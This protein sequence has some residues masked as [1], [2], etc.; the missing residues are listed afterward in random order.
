MFPLSISSIALPAGLVLGSLAVGGLIV[1][2]VLANKE[3]EATAGL[4][5][6]QYKKK[7][8]QD[9]AR[10]RQR[11]DVWR[12]RLVAWSLVISF[13]LAFVIAAGAGWLSFGN[14]KKY[15]LGANGGDDSAAT[16]FALLLDAGALVFSLMRLF[17]AISARSS[18]LTR[19]GL[20]TFIAASTVMNLM[21]A[22]HDPGKP[23]S[24]GAILYVVIPPLVYAALLEM[25]LWKAEQLVLGLHTRR[26]RRTERGYSLWMWA[27]WPIGFPIRLWRRLREQGRRSLDSIGSTVGGSAAEQ[28]DVPEDAQET[29]TLAATDQ[30]DAGGAGEE[31]PA[32]PAIVP[33]QSSA[34]PVPSGAAPVGVAHF[35]A[36]AHLASSAPVDLIKKVRR[37]APIAAAH[38]EGA[39]EETGGAPMV[40][41]TAATLG[42]EDRFP[43]AA[44]LPV[45]PP[46]RLTETPAHPNPVAAQSSAHPV[47]VTVG[48]PDPVDVPE[49]EPVA[50]ATAA[51]P[52]EETRPRR[53]AARVDLPVNTS[54]GNKKGALKDALIMEIHKGDL[55]IF[56]DDPKVSNAV[57]YALNKALFPNKPVTEST[58]RRYVKELMPDLLEV[59][60]ELEGA[61]AAP[62]GLVADATERD[63]TDGGPVEATEEAQGQAHTAGAG[64]PPSAHL[65]AELG[66]PLPAAHSGTALEGTSGAVQGPVEEV[67]RAESIAAA[68]FEGAP[69]RTDGAAEGGRLKS[70]AHQE[71][72]AVHVGAAS[73]S[74][75]HAVGAPE[76]TGGAVEGAP[77]D[78]AAHSGAPVDCAEGT[79]GTDAEEEGI[80]LAGPRLARSSTDEIEFAHSL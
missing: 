22:H 68:H 46:A 7:L 24:L 31:A 77:L 73:S 67:R 19:F 11:R 25:L 52:A 6:E 2:T 72:S 63:L 69:E 36:P 51:T 48:E 3:A 26:K 56:S 39:P 64:A 12:R 42:A 35:E 79:E 45:D 20:G 8:Q 15:A 44:H 59:R 78:S 17:E 66:E 61:P 54:D 30:A 43:V 40:E 41:N 32:E 50:V 1:H 75:A 18:N 14:Q 27:P 62:V 9:D 13:V 38:F 74:A 53:V 21:H 65:D 70:A 80:V 5:A 34:H 55:R 29:S 76:E 16:V 60:A 71:E 4:S 57:A 47:L 33:A 58:V 49:A 10:M 28:E 23:P 37:A